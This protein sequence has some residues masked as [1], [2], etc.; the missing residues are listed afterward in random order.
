ME[1]PP[2]EWRSAPLK[3]GDPPNNGEPPK[4]G[5]P[6]PTR[7]ENPPRMENTPQEWRT[8]P[9]HP[10]RS[11][12]QHTVNDRPVRILLE[13]ILVLFLKTQYARNND[14]FVSLKMTT[15]KVDKYHT[16]KLD[17]MYYLYND[18]SLVS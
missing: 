17:T 12:L 9:P 5:E 13:C 8:P 15:Q 16:I 14:L 18:N 4:N 10:P 3:N 11:M 6:P 2:Q 1:N 7:M